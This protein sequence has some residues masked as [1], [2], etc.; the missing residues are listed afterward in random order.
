MIAQMPSDSCGSRASG[1]PTP[2]ESPVN[3]VRAW[4]IR[5]D[6]PRYGVPLNHDPRPIV[7]ASRTA[8]NCIANQAPGSR[9]QRSDRPFDD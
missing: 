7:Q 3:S 1:E 8:R 9:V 2:F 6:Q 4:R 5:R